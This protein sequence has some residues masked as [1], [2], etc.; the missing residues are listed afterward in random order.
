LLDTLDRL[1][2]PPQAEAGKVLIIDDSPSLAAF[3]A[4]HLSGSGLRLPD[5]HRPA[6]KSGCHL[7]SNRP[8]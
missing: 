6:E 4:A 8:N 2:A 7:S 1:T 3:Y 5:R